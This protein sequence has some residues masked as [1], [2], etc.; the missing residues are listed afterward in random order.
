MES[1]ITP[2]MKETKVNIELMYIWIS[3]IMIDVR[4]ANFREFDDDLKAFMG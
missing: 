4:K 1:S 3:Q 2:E